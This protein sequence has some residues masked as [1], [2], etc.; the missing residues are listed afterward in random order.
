MHSMNVT[1]A[2]NVYC[3]ILGCI[4]CSSALILCGVLTSGRFVVFSDEDGS[5]TL[6]VG[7]SMLP[8]ELDVLPPQ[9]SKVNPG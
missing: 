8:G 2:A 4:I 5:A 3:C 9:L 7:Y 6:N 1:N